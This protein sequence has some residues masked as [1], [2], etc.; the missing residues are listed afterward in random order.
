LRAIDALV[1]HRPD[2]LHAH[3]LD[4]LIPCAVAAAR[5]RVPL[6]YDAHELYA[7]QGRH[8][9]IGQELIRA[10]EDIVMRRA[11]RILAAN[12]SRADVMWLEY[13]APVR[14]VALLNC[15]EVP[16]DQVVADGSLRAWVADQG[17][18]WNRIVL[19]QGGLLPDRHL[20]ELAQAARSL[21]SEIGVVFVGAGPVADEIRGAGGD[22]VLLHPLVPI[23]RLLSF[24]AGADVGVVTY[25]NTCRNNYLC[26]PNKLF[27]YAHAGLPMAVGDLPELGRTVTDFDAG[28]VFRN[29]DAPSM[30]DEITSLLRDEARLQRAREGSARLA[31]HFTWE[32]EAGKLLAVYEEVL[33][34]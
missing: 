13:L 22:R 24:I 14:P 28:V 2:A 5:L 12:E 26:A 18:R 27:D 32:R 6:I 8:G 15:P 34:F 25:A 23:D 9:W 4:A 31:R 3:D 17:R 19:Y 29:G 10:V 30:A 33:P 16:R 21:P 1:R 20:C 11:T 7:E